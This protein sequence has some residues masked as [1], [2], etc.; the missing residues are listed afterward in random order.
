[1][2]NVTNTSFIGGSV[3]TSTDNRES[4]KSNHNLGRYKSVP[5]F[6]NNYQDC[7]TMRLMRNE[8]DPRPQALPLAIA[9]SN[10]LGQ[11]ACY[12]S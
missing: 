10:A 12:R 3:P 7:V 8:S 2:C 6:I 1:M 11:G 5:G 9:A 4:N